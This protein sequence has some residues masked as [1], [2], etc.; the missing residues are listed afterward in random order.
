MCLT[1]QGNYHPAF[2]I[3]FKTLEDY[4]PQDSH[5][6][7]QLLLLRASRHVLLSLAR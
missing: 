5:P 2:V 1:N 3:L 7:P 4:V 6:H